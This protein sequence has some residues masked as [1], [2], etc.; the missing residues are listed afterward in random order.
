MAVLGQKTQHCL[1]GP[2]NEAQN[3]KSK[4]NDGGYSSQR[5]DRFSG[6][7]RPNRIKVMAF[8]RPQKRP[9]GLFWP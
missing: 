8:L 9:H 2:E 4:L 6:V 5:G 1:L 7:E 3:I